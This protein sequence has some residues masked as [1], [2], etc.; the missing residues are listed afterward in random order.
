MEKN[1]S[2]LQVGSSRAFPEVA[3]ETLCVCGWNRFVLRV[4]KLRFFWV[5][6]GLASA[7]FGVAGLVGHNEN[8]LL[9]LVLTPPVCKH[10]SR[11]PAVFF[12]DTGCCF[13]SLFDTGFGHR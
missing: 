3:E 4:L 1:I 11:R 12:F 13:R 5:L 10:H 9:G 2:F 8:S 6:Q 7:L